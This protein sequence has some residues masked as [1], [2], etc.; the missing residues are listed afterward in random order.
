MLVSAPVTAGKL[1]T[2]LAAN[3]KG[4]IRSS[5]PVDFYATGAGVLSVPH[6]L[7][8]IPD[9]VFIERVD[10]VDV[11]AT[12]SQR[13]NSWTATICEVTASGAGNVRAWFVKRIA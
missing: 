10:N 13:A 12:L 2:V 1:N 9:G 3:E 4:L 6:D 8:E 11:Y 7:G 5:S